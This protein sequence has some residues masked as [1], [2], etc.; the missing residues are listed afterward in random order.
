MEITIDTSAIIAVIGNESSKRSIIEMTEGCA[1]CCPLSVHWEVGNAFSAMMK[2]KSISLE[3]ARKALKAYQKIP[4]KRIDVSLEHSLDI[5]SQF[6]LYAYD[7]YIVQ[8]A[9]Q[10]H[11]PLLTLDTRLIAVAQAMKITVLE[12]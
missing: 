10:T 11:T 1:L 3:L 4:I 7:A 12:V 5:A 9:R 8:C 2:R 6:K